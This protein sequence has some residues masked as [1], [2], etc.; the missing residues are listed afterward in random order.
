MHRTQERDALTVEQFVR[1]L[2]DH[3]I[4]RVPGTA[5]FITRQLDNIPPLIADHVR[6]M[7]SLYEKAI[8]LTVDFSGKPRVNP[9]NRI[10][11]EQLGEG[12]WHVVICFGFVEVPDI[13]KALHSDKA[14]CPVDL[15]NA[16]YFSERDYVVQR[17]GRPRMP[18]WRRLLFSFLSRNSVHLADRFN[19]PAQNFVQI[20]REIE[21]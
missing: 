9:D 7:G 16:I 13:A 18:M 10:R 17:S 15:D 11:F 2:R 6:Q 1:Q 8:A 19:I 5:I 20:S 3:K 14:Q 4:P 21:V 12:F